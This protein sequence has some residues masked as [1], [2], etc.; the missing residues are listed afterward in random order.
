[1]IIQKQYHRSLIKQLFTL[2]I[3]L[4]II[5]CNDSKSPDDPKAKA[6]EHND[7]KFSKEKEKDADFIADLAEINLQGIELG[8]LAQEK[9][10]GEVK[11][12]G[13]KMEEIH[14]KNIEELKKLASSKSI[15]VPEALSDKGRDNQNQLMNKSGDDFI[16]SLCNRMVED[17]K[18]AIKKCEKA[19][20][21]ASDIEIKNWANKTLPELRAHLDEA[22]ICEDKYK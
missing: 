15:T 4:S 6:E 7:A 3:G 14:K 17:H 11:K 13:K 16:K 21:D 18:S 1:M 2:I 8:K 19:S 22:M 9:G 20:T 5:S 12:M 10:T